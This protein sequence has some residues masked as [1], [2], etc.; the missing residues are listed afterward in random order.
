V[1]FQNLYQDD[2]RKKCSHVKS[3]SIRCGLARSN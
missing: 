1:G 2:E 3:N